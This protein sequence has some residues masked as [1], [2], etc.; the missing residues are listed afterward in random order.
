MYIRIY[1]LSYY[2]IIEKLSEDKPDSLVRSSILSDILAQDESFKPTKEVIINAMKLNHL[3][4]YIKPIS[5]LTILDTLGEGKLYF[6]N[7]NYVHLL[8]LQCNRHLTYT[9]INAYKI[10]VR[11]F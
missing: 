9:Y 5:S 1:I 10:Y 8:C 7:Y 4:T 2:F 11:N 6:C 3:N